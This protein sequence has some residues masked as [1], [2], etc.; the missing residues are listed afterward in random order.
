[1]AYRKRGT[2]RENLPQQNER[3]QE[4]E[5]EKNIDVA[6]ENKVN[7]KKQQLSDKVLSQKEEIITDAQDDVKIADEVKKSS[8]EESK[9]LLEILKT[10][11][12][13]QK[14]IQYEILQKTIPTFEP[15]ESILKKLEDI[16]PEQAK[17][18][19]KLFRIFEP[20][21][22][23]IYRANGERELRN[24]WYWKLKRD[25]LPDGD[26]DVREYF[27]N[28]YDQILIEMPDYLLLKDM[29]VENKN[30]RDAGKVVD[31]ETASIC[32][33]IFQDEE[34]EGVVRRFIA[35]MRQQVQ[36]DRNVVNYPSILHPIDHAFNEYFLNHQ[37]VEPLNN[38]II[39]NYI[40]ERIRND[41]NYIL[42]MDMN[43][44]STA[45]YI[46]P[47]LLQDR[48]N[49]HDNF[50]SLWDT[51]TTSN[52]IL[53]RSVVPDLKEKEL[54]STE[55]Q[56]QK[57]SQ[58]LQLEALT[59]QSETQFLAGINSQAANDCFKT[60]I[61][62]MLSQRTMSLEFVTT[63]YMSLIS[64][65]WLLTVIPNDMFLRESLVACELAIINTIVYPAF[66]MQRMHYRN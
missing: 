13:H 11:E 29:A 37:L 44:P 38:E 9:Q 33:A 17:K 20:R 56:I 52:Y 39:F 31:S 66:G 36:A 57:M 47:N 50:E 27:L 3:L 18:Q 8:K 30:S 5:V 26:Y 64:G 15:K 60:L 46:R 55:A 59:I 34:T 49:L 23:P 21:Q 43:L 10:K 1:M 58:D 28:L 53:A 62:A 7:N 19:T 12:D 65:M 45:R 54:V 25:T 24:R 6:M 61:A 32:D 4:K 40:P 22:L 51:I 35:D 63:N 14:E 42:N 48:L 41:V 16:K 2:R